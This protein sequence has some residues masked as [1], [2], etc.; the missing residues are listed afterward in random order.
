MYDP[1]VDTRQYYLFLRYILMS[2]TYIKDHF[3]DVYV[4][5]VLVRV[6]SALPLR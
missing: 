3:V 6:V 2:K 1:K 4:F 5:N